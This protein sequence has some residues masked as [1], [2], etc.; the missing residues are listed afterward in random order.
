MRLA[1][2]PRLAVLASLSATSALSLVVACGGEAPAPVAPTPPSPASTAAAPAPA[3]AVTYDSTLTGADPNAIDKSAA[4]CDDFYQFACGGWMAA[5]PIPDDEARWTRSFSVIN[6]DNQKALRSILERDAAGNANGDAYGQ[7]LGDFWASCTDEA[8]IE[9]RGA[10][11][12]APELK[13]IA[14]V[15]D[16]K[17]LATEL[18][19]LHQVGVGAA[20]DVGSEVDAKDAAHVIASIQQGG[21]GLPERDFYFR[22]DPKAKEVRAAYEAHVAATFEL[23]GDKPKVAAA[24]AK[25]VMKLE[26]DLAGASMTKVDLRDPQKIYHHTTL[27]ELK[28]LAPDVAWDGYLAGLGFPGVAAFNVGQP[29]FVKKVDAMTKSVPVAQWKT[30]LR[31]HLA[32]A[33][34]PYLSQK[35]VDEWFKF[36]QTLTGAK[37]LQPRWKRCVKVVD[38]MLGEALA[39]P[40]VKAYLGEDGKQ[41][42][43]AMVAG[44]ETSMKTDLD[45]L[46][47]MD[48]ATR[49]QAET[50]LGKILNKIGYPAKWRNYDALAPQVSRGSLWANVAAGATFENHRE[51]AK[52]GQPTDKDEW[53]M[54]PPTVNAY[55][56]ATTNE[57]VF[58]AGILQPPFYAATQA[59]AMN[60]GA[61]G[62]VVGHELTHGFDDEGRQFDAEG[63]LRDWWSPSVSAEFDRRAGCVEK[64]FDDF[65]AVDDVHVKGK[66][67]LGENIADLGGL[68]LAFATFQ[69]A[70]KEHP[71]TPPSLGGFTP[72]QTFFLGYA[73]AWCTNIRPAQARLFAQTDPHSPAKYRVLGP[74]SNLSE[75]ASAFQCKAGDK[76][77]RGGDQQCVVW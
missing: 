65:V 34:S 66:L 29:D 49:T 28:K 67:T 47:W 12:L 1:R 6:E 41:A 64:Q 56:D 43:S 60:F 53:E 8:G 63:N 11:D 30:Y 55:Y 73:Q 48:D 42:A 57:M 24:N 22:D 3:P 68:K 59:P 74:L 71:A 38:Q 35:F 7:S 37:T 26:T 51:L 25:T 77:V 10:A 27:D 76:M 36:R 45:G 16:A 32:R 44:I 23:L 4:P 5:T 14:A 72:E 62:M 50:K 21:L 33:A 13:L 61:I 46:S 40:F 17:S 39:Q 9:K 69:R 75:F 70:E 18:A 15:R 31:W 58:P 2:L 19:H 52:A 54:T 20:W